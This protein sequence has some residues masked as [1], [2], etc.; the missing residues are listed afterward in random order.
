MRPLEWAHL[1]SRGQHI[2]GEPWCSLPELTVALCASKYEV[3]CHERLDRNL[4]PDLLCELRQLAL[5]RL[6]NRFPELRYLNY[7][8]PL[9]GVR[10][11]VVL[12]ESNGWVYDPPSNLIVKR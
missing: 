10:E 6:M 3:G 11:A 9:G 4:V 2:V 12:L 7:G 5:M 1:F 8:D